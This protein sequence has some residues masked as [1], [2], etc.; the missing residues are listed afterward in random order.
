MENIAVLCG[1]H[2]TAPL[3]VR[4]RHQNSGATPRDG[5]AGFCHSGREAWW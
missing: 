2:V 4:A 3:P 5:G 1:G